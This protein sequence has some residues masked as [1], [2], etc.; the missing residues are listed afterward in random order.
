MTL[1]IY[2]PLIMEQIDRHGGINLKGAAI[3]DG[4]CASD[5]CS[6]S[7]VMCCRGQQRGHVRAAQRVRPHLGQLLLRPWHVP[8]GG[9]AQCAFRPSLTDL[10]LFAQIEDACGV[11]FT[12]E[13]AAC[14]D[15]INQMDT[16]VG[17]VACRC[18]SI[19]LMFS[20]QAVL[21]LQFVPVCVR[22]IGE[23]L[24][25]TSMTRAATTR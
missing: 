18:D 10:Q 24:L 3:G 21:H 12:V 11:N 8:A 22:L 2:I 23:W 6:G 13:S 1:Q 4:C 16:D 17:C 19:A 14:L 9:L 20:L 7:T 25:Q 15:L 5:H